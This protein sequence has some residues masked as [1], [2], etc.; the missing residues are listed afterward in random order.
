ME[1]GWWGRWREGFWGGGYRGSVKDRGEV[2][3]CGDGLEAFHRKT[4]GV[5]IMC[6]GTDLHVRLRAADSESIFTI[7]IISRSLLG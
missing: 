2:E 1:V 4:L 7:E 6:S 3:S 5:T